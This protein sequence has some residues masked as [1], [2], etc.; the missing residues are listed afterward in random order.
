[1]SA[2]FI[3]EDYDGSLLTTFS[4]KQ[5]AEYINTF[6]DEGA[7]LTVRTKQTPQS[8][9]CWMCEKLK[10]MEKGLVAFVIAHNGEDI[11][12]VC[13]VRRNSAD[14]EKGVVNFGLSV[15]KEYRGQGIGTELLKRGI[16]VAK[17]HFNAHLLMIEVM[18]PNHNA[19][20]LY[21]RLGFVLH[22]TYPCFFKISDQ[23]VDKHVLIYSKSADR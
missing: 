4:P 19:L 1:M 17:T 18:A 15:R 3:E 14:V 12:G 16:R 6:V 20:R 9:T 2:V 23:C 11:I 21:K 8:E 10:A 22:T 5:W 7:W 13:E